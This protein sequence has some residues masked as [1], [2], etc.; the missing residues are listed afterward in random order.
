MYV[1]AVTCRLGYHELY[2]PY[3]DQNK[4]LAVHQPS[5]TPVSSAPRLKKKA[6]SLMSNP[7]WNS[8]GLLTSCNLCYIIRSWYRAIPRKI[9]SYAHQKIRDLEP[10]PWLQRVNAALHSHT[11]V[12]TKSGLKRS[13]LCPLRTVSPG[14]QHPEVVSKTQHY[15]FNS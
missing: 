4:Q 7:S 11:P 2:T 1:T 13:V 14:T 10:A 6:W 9:L 5:S 12:R 3:E 15:H 8:S